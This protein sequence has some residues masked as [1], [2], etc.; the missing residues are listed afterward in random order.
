MVREK[1]GARLTS[2]LTKEIGDAA[3]D[4]DISRRHPSSSQAEQ[5]VDTLADGDGGPE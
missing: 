3:V 1:A 2:L 4:W 5:A